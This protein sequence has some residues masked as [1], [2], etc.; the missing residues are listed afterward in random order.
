M[1]SETAR[2]RSGGC[3]V[4]VDQQQFLL[5]RERGIV[6]TFIIIFVVVDLIVFYGIHFRVSVWLGT[7]S[8]FLVFF[9]GQIKD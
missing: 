7:L 5:F 3:C 6:L 4:G 2:G 1:Q 9:Y 8:I